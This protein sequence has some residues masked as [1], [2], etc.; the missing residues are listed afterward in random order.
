MAMKTNKHKLLDFRDSIEVAKCSD[1]ILFSPQHFRV[2]KL[3]EPLGK[4]WIYKRW[5]K[6]LPNMD[7]PSDHVLISVDFELAVGNYN[8]TTEVAKEVKAD[9]QGKEKGKVKSAQGNLKDEEDCKQTEVELKVTPG[10]GQSSIAMSAM[11]TQGGFA[12]FR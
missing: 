1:L 8:A 4:A 5:N 10:G 2:L 7:Y 6:T 3:M 9:V 12:P 11:P